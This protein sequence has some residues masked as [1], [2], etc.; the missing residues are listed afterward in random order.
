VCTDHW[1]YSF[2]TI[3]PIVRNHCH[4][5]HDCWPFPCTSH[6]NIKLNKNPWPEWP[7][8]VGEV[9]ANFLRIEGAMWSEWR[10]LKAEFWIFWTG[11][12]TFLPSS[13]SVAITRP[14][15]PRSRPTTSQKIWWRRESN[16][17]LWFCSQNLR[18]VDDRGSPHEKIMIFCAYDAN[19]C[20]GIRIYRGSGLPPETGYPEWHL[21]RFHSVLPNGWSGQHLKLRHIWFSPS[22]FRI[23]CWSYCHIFFKPHFI[24]NLYTY[25]HSANWYEDWVLWL[26]KGHSLVPFCSY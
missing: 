19:G 5:T 12:A 25:I 8:L 13:S 20:C 16:P 18:S 14:S 24:C 9:S 2:H 21:S 6:E 11:T 1:L 17:D 23:I 22:S 3:V 15:G 10:I 4:V 26:G 7:L